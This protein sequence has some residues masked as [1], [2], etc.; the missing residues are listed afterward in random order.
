MIEIR[1]VTKRFGPHTALREIDLTI[2]AGESVVLAG[3]NGAGKTTLLRMLANLTRPTNGAITIDGL[4]TVKDAAVLRRQI[5]FLS[6][7]T[8]LY[9][10]LTAHQNLR[11]YARLYGLNEPQHRIDDLLARVEL[12]SRQH[13]LVRTFS[14]GMKQ[15]LAIARAVLHKPRVL[16]MDEP[17]TG[18]DP[19][20]T[21]SL[22]ALLRSLAAKR[23]TLLM[24]THQLAEGTVGERALILYR[25]QIL[26]DGPLDD[27]ATF[28]KRYRALIARAAASAA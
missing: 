22:N 1:N 17:Y 20:A 24:T 5:G 25:G 27:R 28:L 3:P 4:D 11:F 21:T 15:R 23:C 9:E 8:L 19:F 2:A 26:N 18:L 6:H 10:N 16:L 14:R 13:D 12:D 7:R